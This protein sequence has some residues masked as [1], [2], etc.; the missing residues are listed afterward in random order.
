MTWLIPLDDDQGFIHTRLLEATLVGTLHEDG[1]QIPLLATELAA[2]RKEELERKRL[3]KA[4]DQLDGTL[5]KQKLHPTV[6]AFNV[7]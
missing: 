1:Q 5:K 7:G 3:M 6:V 4:L 2:M